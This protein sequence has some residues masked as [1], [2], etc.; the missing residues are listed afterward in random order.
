MTDETL[1]DTTSQTQS[2]RDAVLVALRRA[3]LTGEIGPGEKLREVHVAEMLDVSRSTLREAA[4][5]LVHEGLLV[6]ERYKGI[7]VARLD[8]KTVEDLSIMRINLET[9]A[10]QTIAKDPSG[11][12]QRA[13]QDALANYLES[14][15]S[16][17]HG[18]EQATHLALHRAIWFG[19]G[20]QFI[21][22]VWNS[23][24][25]LINLTTAT[26]FAARRG[27]IERQRD[28]HRELVARILSG[29]DEEIAAAVKEHIMDNV[30]LYR[31]RPGFDPA[32]LPSIDLSL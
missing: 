9:L 5:Q 14:G 16:G 28:R 10:A 13:L 21:E 4:Q 18:I 26:D 29:D 8:R 19:S 6:Q 30:L 12:R 20:N 1:Q 23:V 25:S 11:E 31:L 22:R 3:I 7:R 15:N 17:D 24:E 2:R 27:D 32:T